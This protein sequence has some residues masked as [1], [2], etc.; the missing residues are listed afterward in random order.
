M[1]MPQVLK[2]IKWRKES[3]NLTRLLMIGREKLMVCP[4]NLMDPKKNV[5]T[6][7]LNFSGLGGF[8]V[9]RLDYNGA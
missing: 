3:N 5:V 6:S 4:K 1:W 8:S 2:Q 9:T 7:V